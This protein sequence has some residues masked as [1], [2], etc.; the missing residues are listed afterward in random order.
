MHIEHILLL[1][2]L[3]THMN[4]KVLYV[5]LNDYKNNTRLIIILPYAK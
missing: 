4:E 1:P 5:L 3:K 2:I